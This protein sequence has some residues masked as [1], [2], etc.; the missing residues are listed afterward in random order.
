MYVKFHINILTQIESIKYPHSVKYYQNKVFKYSSPKHPK[1]LFFY[2]RPKFPLFLIY[3]QINLLLAFFV[4]STYIFVWF[5]NDASKGILFKQYCKSFCTFAD[6]T[7]MKLQ[8]V[9]LYQQLWE[10]RDNSYLETLSRQQKKYCSSK[11]NT[12][13][14]IYQSPI[15]NTLYAD[16]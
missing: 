13:L 10:K 4:V 8:A 9:C 1:I 11:W 6:L 7:R 14:N 15:N 16:R 2:L 3:F 5:W 12:V